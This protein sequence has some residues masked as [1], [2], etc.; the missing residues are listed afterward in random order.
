MPL[1][2]HIKSRQHLWWGGP[3]RRLRQVTCEGQAH[4]LAVFRLDPR[5][6]R[7]VLVATRMDIFFLHLFAS[8]RLDEAEI[9]SQ[10]IHHFNVCPPFGRFN[11][12]LVGKSHVFQVVSDSCC[13]RR[14]Q[15]H[16]GFGQHWTATAQSML[17]DG[18]N[19]PKYG[20]KM[21]NMSQTTNQ[22]TIAAFFRP[23]R[24]DR[25]KNTPAIQRVVGHLKKRD[26]TV[27]LEWSVP[28]HLGLDRTAEQVDLCGLYTGASMNTSEFPPGGLKL[29]R[30]GRLVRW[31]AIFSCRENIKIKLRVLSG[32]LVTC[33]NCLSKIF[34]ILVTGPDKLPKRKVLGTY[35]LW[36]LKGGPK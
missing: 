28:I 9:A 1:Q 19:H 24:V 34:L 14:P 20:W 33:T 30:L 32:T 26:K 11:P 6:K 15:H 18:A 21:E 2:I 8:V 35:R 29:E 13:R 22:L 10:W 25:K 4:R 7:K 5:K 12:H 36:V 31:K 17:N 23:T 16:P 27:R 3:G